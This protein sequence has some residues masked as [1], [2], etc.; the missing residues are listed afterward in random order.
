[1]DGEYILFHHVMLIS[2]YNDKMLYAD[3]FINTNE[4]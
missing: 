1:M 3:F 2:N 4:S